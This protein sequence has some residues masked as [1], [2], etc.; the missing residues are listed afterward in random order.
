M[1]S[2]RGRLYWERKLHTASLCQVRPKENGIICLLWGRQEINA[3][4]SA[5][6]QAHWCQG[7]GHGPFLFLVF[8]QDSR[9]VMK[10]DSADNELPGTSCPWTVEGFFFFFFPSTYLC[11]KFSTFTIYNLF[12]L[13]ST[14]SML[15]L[16]QLDLNCGR[17]GRGVFINLNPLFMM[18]RKMCV[19]LFFSQVRK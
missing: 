16:K 18:F 8:F 17:K 2:R 14:C 1:P 19:F 9:S 10:E 5:W 13:Q 4:G 6:R 11:G 12:S 3:E 15:A 7:H